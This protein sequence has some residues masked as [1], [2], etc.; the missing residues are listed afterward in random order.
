MDS[1]ASGGVLDLK[2]K[3][4]QGD[5]LLDVCEALPLDG[6][7][8]VFGRSGSGKTSLL[9]CIAGFERGEG[10]VKFRDQNWFESASRRFVA[11]HLRGVGYM[12]QNAGLFPH[13][14]VTDNL[15]FAEQRSAKLLVG[16]ARP[17]TAVDFD[18]VVAAFALTDLLKRMPTQLSG[19]ESQRVALARTLLTQPSLLLL[20][21][22]LAALDDGHKA[23]LLPFLETLVRDFE[24]PIIYVS[25]DVEEVARL[26][27]RLLVL[28][29]GEVVAFG[30]T[31]DL[32][33]RLDIAQVSGR[34][35]ASALV[36][37][38]VLEH[39]DRW[40]LTRLQVAGQVIS[41]PQRGKFRVGDK[42]RLRV[43]ARDVALARQAPQGLSIRNVFSG[44]VHNLEIDDDTPFAEVTVELENKEAQSTDSSPVRL[45]SRITRAAADELQLKPG[46]PVFA[47]VK[48]VTFDGS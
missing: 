13:L 15:R 34:F 32:F 27:T 10:H 44:Q 28:D 21:E 17:N 37:A 14:D 5:F 45:R 42:V 7:T 46:L 12:F 20:D 9:R 39:D 11:P 38:Q 26:A 1:V 24:L 29:S 22:P 48:S 31:K 16:S 25:H 33:E 41:V 6:V 4:N 19:G 40:M 35:D 23:E 30:A 18:K 36:D 3:L 43:Q 8:A 47:L 2:L